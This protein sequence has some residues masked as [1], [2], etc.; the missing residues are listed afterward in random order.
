MK[1][2]EDFCK[3]LSANSDIVSQQA[4]ATKDLTPEQVAE[5]YRLILQILGEYHL[6]LQE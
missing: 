5:V 1:H 3:S 2:F 6:W 4:I